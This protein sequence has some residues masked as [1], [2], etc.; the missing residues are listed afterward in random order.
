MPFGQSHVLWQL[1]ATN[2]SFPAGRTSIRDYLR[3]VSESEYIAAL[4]TQWPKEPTAS[5]GVLSLA[6]LAVQ[7]HPQSAILWFLRGQL[8]FMSPADYIF[9]KL[10]AI[11]SFEKAVELD[12][13]LADAY[14]QLRHDGVQDDPERREAEKREKPE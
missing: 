12:P 5:R 11:T 1:Q 13:S 14:R 4:K 10:D 3:I 8:M 7:E 9:S 6:C 2:S